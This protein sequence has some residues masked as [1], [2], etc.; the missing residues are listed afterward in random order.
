L[1][2]KTCLFGLLVSP[3]LMRARGRHS[4]RLGLVT[5]LIALGLSLVFAASAAA[6]VRTGSATDGTEPER[7]PGSI[8]ITGVTAQYDTAGS[9]QVAV[10]TAA[11]PPV[12]TEEAILTAR[13]GVLFGSE[14][15]EPIAAIVGTYTQPAAV[16]WG[17]STGGEGT[18]SESI[19]GTTTTIAAAGPALANQSY[20]CVEPAIYAVG[21]EGELLEPPLEELTGP[22]VLFGPPATPPPSTPTPSNP[23][24]TTTPPPPAPAPKANLTFPSTT[25][26]V[27]RNAWKKV[28]VK[29]TNTGNAAAG[30]VTLKIGK[31]GGVTIKPKSGLLKLKSIAAGKFKVAS[32]K[33]KLTRKAK[34]K[35]T[36]TLTLSGAKGLKATGVVTLEAW[37]KPPPKKK[38]KKGGKEEASPAL[39][40]KIFYAYKTEPSSSATLIGYAFIDGEWAYHGVPAEGLPSCTSATTDG[41]KEGAEGC[42]KYSYDPT[43]GTVKIGSVSGKLNPGGE[44]E[45]DGETYSATSIPPAGT[46]L[47]LE[48]EYIGYSGICGLISGCSTW[49][50]H[51]ILTGSSEFVL[52]RESLT[53]AG[54][55][56]P[57]ETFV[58]A[59]SYPPDQHGT[60]AIEKGARIKLSFVDGSTKVKTFA[61]FL[62]KEGKP[63][64]TVAGVLLGTEY[65]TFANDE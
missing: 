9:L 31:A 27:H 18:G 2:Q 30:K 14:C 26:T 55:S 24:P 7:I 61:Y 44:L 38:G 40:E 12:P 48:Q 19:S 6:E 32:F 45:I 43:S 4:H 53:T 8:D 60:Y 62:N 13:F 49:H 29:I 59:G 58:A 3:A 51:L 57:G 65:F 54:G 63:D 36:L 56:G 37:K 17:A 41:T 1:D 34:A 28:T 64:P 52:S 33:V 20:N 23:P 47:Q 46:K 25:V 50:E 35:S 39:A 11:P 42:V 5:A 22:I 21:E 16:A 10:T 15:V